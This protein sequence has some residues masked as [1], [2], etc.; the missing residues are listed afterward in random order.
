CQ[1]APKTESPL[2][3][4]KR[5]GGQKPQRRRCRS[6]SDFGR[7]VSEGF[8]SPRTRITELEAEME[9]KNTVRIPNLALAVSPLVVMLVVIVGGVFVFDLRVEV[10]LMFAVT[11]ASLLAVS[12]GDRCV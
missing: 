7:R 5:C 1:R 8:G 6:S 11:Y 10:V 9:N 3:S 4:A 12:L 2:C